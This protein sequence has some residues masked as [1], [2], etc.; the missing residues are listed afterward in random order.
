M[1]DAGVCDSEVLAELEIVL[2]SL[3]T[4]LF[5]EVVPVLNSAQLVVRHQVMEGLVDSLLADRH[6]PQL[7]NRLLI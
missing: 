4:V 6:P 5:T 1:Q 3:S 2:E 7:L